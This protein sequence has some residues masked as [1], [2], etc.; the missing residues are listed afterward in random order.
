[1]VVGFVSIFPMSVVGQGSLSLSI[2]RNVGMAFGGF[3]Q[4]SY[5][6]RGSGPEEI[7]NLTV[8]FNGDEVHFV[9]GN[10]IAWLFNTDDYPEGFT[11]I[12]LLGVDVVGISYYASSQVT[13][14]GGIVSNVITIGIIALVVVLIFAKYGPR[15]M[16]RGKK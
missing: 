4:G 11:N 7:Q 13:F 16:S 10:S 3:I 1:L 15:L 8:Y 2:D 5:T 12:T 9:T 6:L 14:I